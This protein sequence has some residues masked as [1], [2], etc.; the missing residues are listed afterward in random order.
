MNDQMKIKAAHIGSWLI[1][2][3]SLVF[4]Q[5][6]IKIFMSKEIKTDTSTR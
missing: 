5:L 1:K 6:Q 2:L 4:E 3:T